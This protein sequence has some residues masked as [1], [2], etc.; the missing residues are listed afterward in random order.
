MKKRYKKEGVES[1]VIKEN[2]RKNGIADSSGSGKSNKLK[3]GD[4][5]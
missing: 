5:N 4:L 3:F 1:K 2:E